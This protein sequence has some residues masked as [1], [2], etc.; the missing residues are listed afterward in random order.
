MLL[1]TLRSQYRDIQYNVLED[2]S[3]DVAEAM[4]MQ[5]ADSFSTKE[6]MKKWGYTVFNRKCGDYRRRKRLHPLLTY[7]DMPEGMISN[8]PQVFLQPLRVTDKEVLYAI[9]RILE[10]YDPKGERL[11]DVRCAIAYEDRKRTLEDICHLYHADRAHIRRKVLKGRRK[12]QRLI[13]DT[14]DIF[15]FSRFRDL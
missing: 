1:K 8:T 3:Q 9:S 6:D 15:D 12:L 2:I 7:N 11:K 13:A 4:L 14:Y 10:E 5:Q